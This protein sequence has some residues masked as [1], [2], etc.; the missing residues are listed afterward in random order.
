MSN[1]YIGS[2]PFNNQSSTVTKEENKS[3][4]VEIIKKDLPDRTPAIRLFR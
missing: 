2:L 3:V 1:E 4:D